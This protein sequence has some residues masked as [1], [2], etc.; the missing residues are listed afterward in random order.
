[1]V[2]GFRYRLY[3]TPDSK[4]I[5]FIDK[6]M[7]IKMYDI[8]NRQTTDVD[9]ALRFMHGGC[10]GFSVSWSPDS[11]WFTY[12]RDLDNYHNA[13]YIYDAQN[14]KNTPGNQMVFIIAIT[15]CLIPKENICTSPPIRIFHAVLQR[16]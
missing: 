2:A 6:A 8:A 12:S 9:Q 11:R 16:Y 3:W 14:K 10:E 5:V 13:V 4:K 7:K 15:R 1:M